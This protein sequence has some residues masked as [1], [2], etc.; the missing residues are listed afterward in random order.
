MDDESYAV[1]QLPRSAS[2][3]RR[4]LLAVRGE[5]RPRLWRLRLFTLRLR[6]RRLL[7]MWKRTLQD[8]PDTQKAD[9]DNMTNE[10]A[11]AVAALNQTLRKHTARMDAA[12]DKVELL[13]G[14]IRELAMM[15]HELNETLV[16]NVVR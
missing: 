12:F 11:A 2:A 14:D 3:P 9:D 10:D 13:A 5:L 1:P 7:S 15:L 4:W 6:G 16:E 8:R